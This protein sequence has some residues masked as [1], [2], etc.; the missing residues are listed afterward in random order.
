M[1]ESYPSIVVSPGG[2]GGYWS[3]WYNNG[4]FGP[5]MY[6]TYVID[7]LIPLIDSELPDDPDRSG[8]A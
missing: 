1:T 2:D 6:E 5:P 3:D 7:Q 8:R 4:A